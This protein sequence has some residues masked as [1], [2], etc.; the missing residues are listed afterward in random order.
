MYSVRIPC[1][2]EDVNRLSG[3]LWEAGTIGIREVHDS[4]GDGVVLIASFE[5]PQPGG[6][7]ED[8]SVDWVAETQRSWKGRCVGERIFVAPWW[9]EEATP[10]SRFRLVHNPGL[11]SG[12]G[13]HSCT[14][15]GLMALEE[16]VRPGCRVVD[17]GT[18][19]GIL[20][21]AA[22]LLGAA[23]A[24]G[25]DPDEAAIGVARENHRLNG[26]DAR[27][28]TGS[29]ECLTDTCADITVANISATV[30]LFLGDELLRIT[31]PG[32]KLILTGFVDA[33]L[34][35]IEQNFPAAASRIFHSGEWRCISLRLS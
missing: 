8:E 14:Q 22:L 3:E 19:S 6:W 17:V 31:A 24:V 15:L 10:Q 2:R 20:A 30:L 1:S 13:E 29:A 16:A 18:G 4:D 11:A 28:V 12:T 26:L 9:S 27:L 33:E 34:A 5:N 21:I 25:L 35:A 7:K 23:S 32:G